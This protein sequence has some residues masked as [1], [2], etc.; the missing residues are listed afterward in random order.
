MLTV[1]DTENDGKEKK[2]PLTCSSISQTSE[3]L[4]GLR[5]LKDS[6]FTMTEESEALVQSLTRMETRLLALGACTTS[7]P[8]TASIQSPLVTPAIPPSFNFFYVD[9]TED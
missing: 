8:I 4:D 9:G 5:W 2:I 6:D 1:I 3:W 7:L